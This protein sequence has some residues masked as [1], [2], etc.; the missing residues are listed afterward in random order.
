LV[1]AHCEFAGNL[2]FLIFLDYENLA[3]SV[4]PAFGAGGVRHSHFAAIRAGD[5]VRR[6][7]RIVGAAAVAASL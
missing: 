5:E 7:H 6:G 4:L 1:T 3:A 2:L